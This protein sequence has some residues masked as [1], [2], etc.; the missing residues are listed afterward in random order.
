LT[1]AA[2]HGLK[3]SRQPHVGPAAGIDQQYPR[4]LPVVGCLLRP[5][6][7][8]SGQGLCSDDRVARI[9]QLDRNSGMAS[10]SSFFTRESATR[11]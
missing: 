7:M 5:A 2:A 3:S 10:A 4:D 6:M 1:S 11:R 9:A 8:Q